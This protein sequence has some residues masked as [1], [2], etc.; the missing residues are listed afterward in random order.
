M[1]HCIRYGQEVE[2]YLEVYLKTPGLAKEDI[3]KA[4][5]ARG[6]ARKEGGE[7]LLDKAR[8]G[9]SAFF[10]SLSNSDRMIW[11][12]FQAVLKL[13][14]SN[15]DLQHHLR[16]KVVILLHLDMVQRLKNKSR[17]VSPMN[18]PHNERR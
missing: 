8:E 4:L 15:K 14:P 13:D 16:R 9:I 10:A 6:N 12:D 2:N 17:Y 7:K 11:V 3:S 1:T 5:L 18:L